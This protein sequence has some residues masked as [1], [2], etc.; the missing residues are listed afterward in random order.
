MTDPFKSIGEYEVKQDALLPS[1]SYFTVSQAL[2]GNERAVI[3]Q[4]MIGAESQETTT[5]RDVSARVSVLLF[6]LRG[7]SAGTGARAAYLPVR[8]ASLGD[9]CRGSHCE[10]WSDAPGCAP[11]AQSAGGGKSWVQRAE[12]SHLPAH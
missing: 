2:F 10:L 1:D 7:G 12:R 6:R 9:M 5:N 3:D 8:P 11:R 4:G